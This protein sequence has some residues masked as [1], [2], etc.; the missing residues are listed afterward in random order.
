MD[1]LLLFQS[2]AAIE[3]DSARRR[4]SAVDPTT[5]PG[6]ASFTGAPITQAHPAAAAGEGLPAVGA[7]G[8]GLASSASASAA[9]TAGFGGSGGFGGGLGSSPN[10][11]APGTSINPATGLPHSAGLTR[12]ELAAMKAQQD[13]GKT[14]EI[15]STLSGRQQAAAQLVGSGPVIGGPGQPG[16][17]TMSE[18]SVLEVSHAF[19]ARVHRSWIFKGEIRRAAFHR[20]GQSANNQDVTQRISTLGH[21][22]YEALPPSIRDVF[23]EPKGKGPEGSPVK[24]RRGSAAGTLHSRHSRV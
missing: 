23:A 3:A 16:S 2:T 12:Q 14:V 6:T 7:S 13:H 10:V 20:E 11:P 24:P 4:A 9:P 15:P 17:P 5:V 1:P 22:T 19:S 8:L 21:K 18:K